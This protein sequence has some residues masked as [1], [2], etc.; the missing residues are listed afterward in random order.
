[1]LKK[2]AAFLLV[3]MFFTSC[4]HLN[5][6]PGEAERNRDVFFP[7]SEVYGKYL[8][9]LGAVRHGSC[10]MFPSCSV[11]SKMAIEKHGFIVGWIMTFDRLLRCGRDE[12]EHAPRFFFNGAWRYYD[13]V[14]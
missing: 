9:S 10:P 3:A 12:T 11:Y 14:E 8:N 4:A 2:N 7:V 6:T 5:E 1:M 13:P